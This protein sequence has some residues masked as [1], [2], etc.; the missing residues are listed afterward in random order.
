MNQQIILLFSLLFFVFPVLAQRTISGVVK[1]AE[2]Q[3]RLPFSDIIIKGTNEGT[4]TNVD[5]Y[6]SLIDVPF[7]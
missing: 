5:G 1:S 6:F 2:N 4:S 7:P 3:E